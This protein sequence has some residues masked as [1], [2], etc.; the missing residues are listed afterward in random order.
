MQEK[1]ILSFWEKD[2]NQCDSKALLFRCKVAFTIQIFFHP[3]KIIFIHG[4]LK[5]L[6]YGVEFHRP[7]VPFLEKESGKQVG[8]YTGYR[9]IHPV[10]VTKDT[11]EKIYLVI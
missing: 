10:Q 9:R 3:S 7:P 4:F 1:I 8:C 2:G 6:L 11:Y 5:F